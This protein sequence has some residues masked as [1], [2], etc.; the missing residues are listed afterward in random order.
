MTHPIIT[1]S[2]G[3]YLAVEGGYSANI[4]ILKG[5]NVYRVLFTTKNATEEDAR[6]SG[7]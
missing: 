5:Y 6:G 2:K 4:P 7:G 3:R 1:T